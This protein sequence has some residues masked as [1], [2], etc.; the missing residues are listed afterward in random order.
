MAIDEDTGCVS[1]SGGKPSFALY[2]LKDENSIMLSQ[3]TGHSAEII[4]KR[5]KNIKSNR[6]VVDKLSAAQRGTLLTIMKHLYKL[7]CNKKWVEE[8]KNNGQDFFD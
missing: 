4:F 6:L 2:E 1:F 8:M 7:F 5:E 3:E